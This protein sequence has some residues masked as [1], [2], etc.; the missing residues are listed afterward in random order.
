MFRVSRWL[1]VTAVGAALLILG[2]AGLLRPLG[3]VLRSATLPLVRVAARAAQ[4]LPWVTHSG[5]FVPADAERVAVLE[6]R[7]TVLAVD[8]TRLRELED[9]NRLLRAQ[10]KFLATSGYDSVGARVISRELANGRALLLIDRG[11]EDGLEVGQAV[12]TAEGICIGKIRQVQERL[13]KVELITDPTSRMAAAVLVA[14]DKAQLVGVL[15]GRG[16]GAA[17]LTYIPPSTDLK[18]DQILVT[19]GT[20]EKIPSNLP[21]GLVNAVDGKPTDPFL[22]AAVEPLIL[23]E[24]V[25]FVSILRPTV[26]APKL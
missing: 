14:T 8:Y 5:Q 20:D 24:R 23:L 11:A 22:T 3:D 12:I 15:E 1:I 19:A 21:L 25:T 7:I 17:V 18:T 9:E 16:N 13:A 4:S 2:L 6:K 10:A 26:L